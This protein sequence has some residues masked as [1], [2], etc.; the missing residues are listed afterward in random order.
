MVAILGGLLVFALFIIAGLWATLLDTRA[1]VA[2]LEALCAPTSEPWHVVVSHN[3]DTL[4]EIWPAG[5]GDAADE[6]T[7]VC[8]LQ[9]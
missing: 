4:P 9:P 8:R 3:R 7:Q 6:P 1:R 5:D 2:E